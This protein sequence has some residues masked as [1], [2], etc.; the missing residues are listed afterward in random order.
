[1]LCFNY[2]KLLLK[3]FELAYFLRQ[4]LMLI[5][6]HTEFIYFLATG[7]KEWWTSSCV[8]YCCVSRTQRSDMLGK[9]KTKSDHTLNEEGR[10][11]TMV[12]CYVHFVT[13]KIILRKASPKGKAHRIKR[14]MLSSSISITRKKSTCER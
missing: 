11:R 4:L 1:M 13:L 12:Y 2:P 8:F 9:E 10:M 14:E 7:N 6:T 5:L 3:L